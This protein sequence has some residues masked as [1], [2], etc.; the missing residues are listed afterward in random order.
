[1]SHPLLTWYLDALDMIRYS[2]SG[3]ATA[4]APLLT[5]DPGGSMP[6][7]SDIRYDPETM[8]TRCPYGPCSR[9][10]PDRN[11]E[12]CKGRGGLDQAVPHKSRWYAAHPKPAV[13]DDDGGVEAPEA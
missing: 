3:A 9:G 6:R 2:S 8:A 7:D 11:T 13:R 4:G 5:V 1:M 10:G 12:R